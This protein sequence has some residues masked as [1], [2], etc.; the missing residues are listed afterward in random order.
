M[1]NWTSASV[2]DA[3]ASG[4][5]RPPAHVMLRE[6]RNGTGWSAS[7]DRS[8]DAL[9][10]S[11]WPSRGIWFA[12][13]EVKVSRSDWLRELK[14]PEKSA[15]IQ[16][17]CN[18][19]WI[20]APAGVVELGE[21][22]ETWG[23]IETG[24]KQKTVKVAPKLEPE[25]PSRAFVA[26]VLRNGA[27]CADT[28]TNAAVKAALAKRDAD[29][30]DM[31]MREKLVAAECRAVRAEGERDNYKHGLEQLYQRIRIFE[32]ASGVRFDHYDNARVGARYAL[33]RRLLEEGG[34]EGI[35]KRLEA[36]A[37][38]VRAAGAELMPEAKGPRVG[39]R[40]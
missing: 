14:D 32:E 6:V 36:L 7:R 9:V 33:A 21:I 34:V 8:A 24:K 13:V 28:A 17:W 40:G 31:T 35:A 22:P 20:A 10:V 39:G 5:F 16:K 29:E 37:E 23:F 4:P 18:Y 12:G 15:D 3:L 11:L 26:A 38:G 30:S 1:T 25:P 27:A 2:L 19:W